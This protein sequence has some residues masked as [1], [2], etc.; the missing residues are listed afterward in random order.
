MGAPTLPLHP[1]HPDRVCWGCER[2][3][4]ADG[5]VCGNGTIRC[6]HPCELFGEDWLTTFGAPSSYADVVDA[7]QRTSATRHSHTTL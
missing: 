2:Y 5:M 7:R 4:P 6:P 3:C 1:R